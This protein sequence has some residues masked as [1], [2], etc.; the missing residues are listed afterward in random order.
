MSE[1]IEKVELPAGDCDILWGYEQIGAWQGITGAQARW[2][3]AARLIPV[4]RL[5]GRN[6]VIAFKS[7]IVA[8]VRALIGK[9]RKISEEQMSD[10]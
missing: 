9:S 10:A 1:T 7:E 5:K 2:R 3:A 8:H 4:H 6:L